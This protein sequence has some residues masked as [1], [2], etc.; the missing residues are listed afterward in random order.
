MKTTKQIIRAILWM[1]MMLF[2]GIVVHAEG[3]SS[4]VVRVGFPVQEGMSYIDENG[5]YAGYLVDYLEQLNLFTDWDIEYVRV[6]GDLNTQLE[7]LMN[8]LLRGEIDMLGTMNHSKHWK[9][10]FCILVTVMGR[11]IRFWQSERM[12]RNGFRKISNIGMES[13]WEPIRD[14]PREWNSLSIMQ[15]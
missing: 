2:C 10:F 4:T 15:M 5:N 3:E 9:R 7:T 14:T 1:I 8:M 6:D 11:V 12:R 13:V